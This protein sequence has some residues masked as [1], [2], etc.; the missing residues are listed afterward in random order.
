[1]EA[2]TGSI[3]LSLR[4]DD[5]QPLLL[6]WLQRR[7]RCRVLY[8][9]ARTCGRIHHKM[10]QQAAEGVHFVNGSLVRRSADHFL[11]IVDAEF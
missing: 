3:S 2:T 4:P 10:Y 6:P 8:R 7:T 9:N 11:L 1:M 5:A